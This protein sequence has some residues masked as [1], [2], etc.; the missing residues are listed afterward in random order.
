MIFY[1]PFITERNLQGSIV[2]VVICLLAEFY[3]I[4]S[5]FPYIYDALSDEVV[6]GGA[7]KEMLPVKTTPHM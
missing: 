1:A 4:H 2:L 6:T 5:S 3:P 7:M